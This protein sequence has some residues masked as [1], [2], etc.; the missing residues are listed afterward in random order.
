MEDEGNEIEREHKEDDNTLEEMSDIS[1]VGDIIPRTSSPS[2]AKHSQQE[3]MEV[4]TEGEL[5]VNVSV[6]EE[7]ESEEK[8]ESALVNE[9][10]SI[11]SRTKGSGHR[12]AKA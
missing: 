2:D 3:L 8:D 9:V 10:A 11:H 12:E 1:E 5:E 4:E 7:T 6:V